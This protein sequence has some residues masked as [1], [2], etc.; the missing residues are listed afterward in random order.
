MPAYTVRGVH[1]DDVG[2]WSC[3]VVMADA[4]ELWTPPRLGWETAHARWLAADEVP[5]LTLHPG[6]MAASVSLTVRLCQNRWYAREKIPRRDYVRA[7]S[8]DDR[9]LAAPQNAATPG[10]C[11]NTGRA[12]R[13][14]PG[15]RTDP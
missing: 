4:G 5:A 1:V 11:G 7:A 6:F 14:G 8:A 10:K 3:T 12:P 9:Q 15:E 2:G 13:A